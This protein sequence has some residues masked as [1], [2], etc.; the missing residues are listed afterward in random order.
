MEIGILNILD[1]KDINA[2]RIVLQVREDCNSWPFILFCNSSNDESNRKSFI[3][4]NMQ[5]YKGDMITI[6][7]KKGT[8]QRQKISNGNINY[9]LYW[10]E[11]CSIWEK[12]T[13]AL[14]VKIADFTYKNL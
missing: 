13:T 1:K 11:D 6:Y 12:N 5:I 4:P 3:F 7:S 9:I 14:L 10:K 8:D 2:E